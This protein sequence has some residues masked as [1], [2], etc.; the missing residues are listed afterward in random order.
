[1]TRLLL[2]T[3]LLGAACLVGVAAPAEAAQRS[4]VSVSE[5]RQVDRGMTRR[6]VHRLFDTGGRRVAFYSTG[7]FSSE[8]RRYRGCPRFSAVSVSYRNGRVRAKSAIWGL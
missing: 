3:C 6:S 8:I 5:Y 4:C 1:M 2:C 7:V